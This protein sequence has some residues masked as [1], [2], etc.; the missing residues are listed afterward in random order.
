MI[1]ND[2]NDVTATISYWHAPLKPDM[3]VIDTSDV[4]PTRFEVFNTMNVG[5]SH[6]R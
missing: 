1:G 4:P 6:S 5:C 2:N 3:S